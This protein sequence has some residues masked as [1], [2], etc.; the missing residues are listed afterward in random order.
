M[1][2]KRKRKKS[3]VKCSKNDII[4]CTKKKGMCNSWRIPCL[5][6]SILAP[7][8]CEMLV[9]SVSCQAHRIS[10]G[11][12]GKYSMCVCVCMR[13]TKALMHFSHLAI[14]LH[15]LA[16]RLFVLY[17]KSVFCVFAKSNIHSLGWLFVW[18][19]RNMTLCA[20][21]NIISWC[22]A[23]FSLAHVHEILK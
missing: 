14:F 12:F 6:P 5:L 10:I 2:C 19:W 21:K 22:L 13:E 17:P 7:F 16:L 15:T 1:Y 4:V 11:A 3:E 18:M 23:I 20:V 9:I 8:I